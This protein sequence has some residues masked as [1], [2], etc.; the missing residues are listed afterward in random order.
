RPLPKPS[1]GMM[2]TV[3]THLEPYRLLTTKLY[4]I[5]PEYIKV[6]VRAIV[7][8]DPRYEGRETD[9]KQVLEEWLQPYGDDSLSGWEFGRPIYKSDV[10]DIIH[11][12]PGIQ[13]IQDVWLMAEGKDVYHEEGGDIRI[14]PNGL[15]IS[16]DHDIEF[17]PSNG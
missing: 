13:Y 16:G 4:I 15:V 9:V 12:V 8:V 2:Q 7:V 10:Y 5:P 17:I 14:P 11:R 6:T 3:L 1:A